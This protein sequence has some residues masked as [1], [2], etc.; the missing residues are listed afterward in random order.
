[1][2]A[3]NRHPTSPLIKP[4]ANVAVQIGPVRWDLVGVQKLQS[5]RLGMTEPIVGTDTDDGGTRTQAVEQWLRKR[6]GTA[7]VAHLQHVD[8]TQAPVIARRL[9]HACLGVAGEQHRPRALTGHHNDTR[10]IGRGI[11]DRT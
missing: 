3:C 9:Q 8:P 4:Y 11:L 5:F 7:V 10:L 2:P 6:Y 1:V